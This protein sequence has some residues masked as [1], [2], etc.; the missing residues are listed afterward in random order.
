MTA[1]LQDNGISLSHVL[2]THWHKDHTGGVPDL[3]AY[4][5]SLAS[6]V[7]KNQPSRGQQPIADGQVFAVAGATVRAVPT[8]GHAADHTCFVLEE[9]GALFTGDN[10]LGHGYSVAEDL[11]AYVASLRTMQ[12]LGCGV[13]YPGHGDVIGDLPS[14]M[15][16]YIEQREAR[17]R[18]VLGA[19][20]EGPAASGQTAPGR[21]LNVVQLHV[22][23][24][25]LPPRRSISV[26]EMAQ[27]LFGELCNDLN[28]LEAGLK[29]LLSQVL[30][31]LAEDGRV[32]FE[33]AGS[34]RGRNWYARKVI[35]IS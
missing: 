24:A 27:R 28:T 26:A 20:V 1:Y 29:P 14:R 17:E 5:P 9:E 34:N 35:T 32:G 25:R 15:E 19:L 12:G 8:P 16:R 30:W 31:K 33:L 21:D 22:D 7:Y 18:D 3:L 11:G 13:G 6:R 2:L 10:V 4:D 23:A